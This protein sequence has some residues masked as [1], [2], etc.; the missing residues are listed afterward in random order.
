[1]TAH[2]SVT[3]DL[4]R[5]QAFLRPAAN[6]TAKPRIK[7][8]ATVA[9]VLALVPTNA[10]AQNETRLFIPCPPLQ[11]SNGEP[12]IAECST[13]DITVTA[14][15]VTLRRNQTGR[16]VTL[17]DRNLIESR[18]TTS[19]A[20]LLSTTP[21]ITVSQ[22][23]G[24]GQTAAVRI[25]GAEDSH[26]LVLID[27]V[28]VNDPGAPAG[29][30]DFGSLLTGNIDRI[31][32]LRGPNSVP[33]GSQAIGGV[34]NIV[35]APVN[36]ANLRAE[37][38][39]RNAKQFVGQ[40]GGRFGPVTA[41]LGGGYFD[42]DGIST[43]KGGTERDAFRQYAA[44][45]RVGVE[46]SSDVSIDL[47]GFFADSRVEFDGF[48]P[49]LFAFADTANYSKTQQLF[50]YAGI[51]ANVLGIKNRLAFTLGDTARDSFPRAGAAPSFIAR[52]RTERFEYQGDASI[53]AAIRSVF[54][55]EHENSRFR[56][57]TDRYS[58]GVT[59]G[60]VQVIATPVDAL[61]LTGGVRVDD[62]RTYGTKATFSANAAWRAGDNTVIR[63]AYGEGF[64]A[65]TLFQL[66][67][68]FGNT[69]LKPETARSYEVG[70][71]QTL[72]DGTLKVGLTA[73]HR[74]TTNQ[75]DFSFAVNPNR[76]FG[77]Y[78]NLDRTRAQGLEATITARPTDNLTMTASYTLV[79]SKDRTTNTALLRRPKH[80]INAS[81]DWTATTWLKLGASI[82]TIS[83]SRD[84]DFVTFSPTSLDGFTRGTIRAA[85]PISERFE[86]YG[87]VENLFNATYETVSGYG[88]ARRN[89]HVGV[90]ATF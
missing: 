43:F 49:P 81:V 38:G 71:E 58:T 23:G 32:V 80:S 65:P 6:K 41:S 33:W 14:T 20:D 13:R 24:P 30:F 25:R 39:S 17:I 52:G 61:T 87:R 57:A 55:I 74:D 18:Q 16:S 21:G 59:S 46:L 72:V 75:I 82:Q 10:F 51:N 77:F 86:L 67:S 48:P 9:F 26:T 78:D 50:G 31:E 73:F 56:D 15:G 76:P 90:R 36:G 60:Y 84:L 64:K 37:Y 4:I 5:G 83:D 22:N 7:C 70:V 63:A 3:P 1:M 79:D 85:V 68:F 12:L 11:D 88:T 29:S 45:A 54:G 47:R 89:A 44:N 53:S 27:G 69:A 8:G 42:D 62:H 35:T 2:I 34:V 66:F 40:A 19:I 28:R